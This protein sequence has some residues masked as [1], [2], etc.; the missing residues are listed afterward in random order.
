MIILGISLGAVFQTFSQAKRIAWKSEEK[1]E[2]ARIARNILSNSSIIHEALTQNETEG[3]LGQEDGWRYRIMVQPL[4][5][6]SSEKGNSLE[7]PGMVNLK[8]CLIHSMGRDE[9]TFELNRWY[10]R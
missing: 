3:V 6:G 8:L 4:E 1:I 5:L 2:C 9:K 10:R 7:I